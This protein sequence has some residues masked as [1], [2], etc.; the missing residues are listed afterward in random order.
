MAWPPARP[1]VLH[2][3]Q[4]GG[5]NLERAYSD[6]YSR[7]VLGRE[8]VATIS[9]SYTIGQ[10]ILSVLLYCIL[11]SFRFELQCRYTLFY[12]QNS[13]IHYSIRNRSPWRKPTIT[14]SAE[15]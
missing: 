2:P 1:K 15:R 6:S 11:E 8:N 5:I 13:I 10:L 9:C 3:R 7:Y 14:I 4:Y 12:H